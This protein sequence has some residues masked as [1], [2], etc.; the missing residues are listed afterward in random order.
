ME[1]AA[2]I[3]EQ[4]EDIQSLELSYRVL[5]PIAHMHDAETDRT[6]TIPFSSIL[7]KYKDYFSTIIIEITLTPADYEKYKYKPKL[8]SDDYYDTTEFWDTILILNNCKSVID[9]DKE[10]IKLYDPTKFKAYLNEVMIIEEEMGNI[11]Y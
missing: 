10:K 5:H 7:N 4:I 11:S 8:V 2:T 9:F 6:I 3:S 1:I